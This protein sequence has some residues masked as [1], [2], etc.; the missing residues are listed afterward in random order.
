M[1]E[2]GTNGVECSRKGASGKRFA[3]AIKFLVNARD[4]QIKCA[5]VLH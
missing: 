5:R 4:L 1:D 2:A 3:G